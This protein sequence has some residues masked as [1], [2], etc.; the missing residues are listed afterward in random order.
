[1]LLEKD[2]AYE[3]A[4][5]DNIITYPEYPGLK[6]PMEYFKDIIKKLN[7]CT[8]GIDADGYN[9]PY[10]YRG[11][12]LSEL[13]SG[14]RLSDIFGL[15][16]EMRFVKS[17]KEIELIKLSCEWGNHAH[18]LLQKYSKPGVSEIEVAM[19]ATYEATLAMTSSL[20]SEYV[21]HGKPAFAEFR[22]QI[23]ALSAFPHVTTQNA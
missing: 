14:E 5:V 15:V 2:Y 10:G 3:N 21:P 12:K 16:E 22:G 8:I 13:T 4:V 9:S 11:P 7:N 19:Q 20:G 6:H 18:K 17:E 23:G 1:P